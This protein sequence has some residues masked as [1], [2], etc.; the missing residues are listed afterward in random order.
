MRALRKL[1]GLDPAGG[2]PDPRDSGTV[3]RIADELGRLEPDRAR[4]LACFAYVLARVAHADLDISPEEVDEMTRLLRELSDLDD[5]QATLVVSL[6][7][8]QQIALGGTENYLVTRRFRELSTRGQRIDLVRCLLAVAAADDSIS[9]VESQEI[10]RIGGELGLT[11]EEVTA[12]RSEYRDRLAVL[13]Q[14]R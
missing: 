5:A 2:Q 9:E 10:L 7:R 12:L 6:A 4:Y 8:T 14:P 11:R 13:R 3:R 1:L